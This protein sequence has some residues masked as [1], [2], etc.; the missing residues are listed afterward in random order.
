M[1]AAVYLLVP[2]PH[3]QNKDISVPLGEASVAPVLKTHQE[4]QSAE[5]LQRS[6]GGEDK[7]AHDGCQPLPNQL[8]TC[9]FNPLPY[10]AALVCLW[11]DAT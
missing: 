8:I 2:T 4:M 3:L 11:L 5:L 10:C 1:E 6:Q 7:I 9:F